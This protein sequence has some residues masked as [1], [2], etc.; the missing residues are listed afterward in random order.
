MNYITKLLS[1]LTTVVL[2]LLTSCQKTP[3]NIDNSQT[4]LTFESETLL[5]DGN[6]GTYSVGYTLKNGIEGIDI[7]AETDEHGHGESEAHSEEFV[8]R[9]LHR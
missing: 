8:L 1:L 6:G 7:A 3:D 2:M 9:Y 5:V 4:T